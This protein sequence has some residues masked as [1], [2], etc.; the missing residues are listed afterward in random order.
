MIS[1]LPDLPSRKRKHEPMVSGGRRA[2][3]DFSS[4]PSA[5]VP[6]V[7]DAAAGLI[8]S[9]IRD[10]VKSIAFKALEKTVQG[11]KQEEMRKELNSSQAQ[12]EPNLTE[13]GPLGPFSGQIWPSRYP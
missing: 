1:D 5:P 7:V 8:K 10:A 3:V 6:T 2:R 4:Y 13:K 12:S 11:E 9:E